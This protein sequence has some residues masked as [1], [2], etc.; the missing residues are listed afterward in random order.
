VALPCPVLSSR[1]QYCTEATGPNA[2]QNERIN[3]NLN[4]H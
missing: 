4:D 2:N 1:V 3:W